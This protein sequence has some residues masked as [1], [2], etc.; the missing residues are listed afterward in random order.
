MAGVVIPTHNRRDGLRSLLGDLAAQTGL[1]AP[2]EVIVVD[3][4]EAEDVSDV[5]ADAAAAG[6]DARLILTANVRATKRN[7]GAEAAGSAIVMFLDDDMRVPPTW[8]AAHLAQQV[9]HPGACVSGAVIFPDAWTQHSNYYR[10][11]Q[12]RHLNRATVSAPAVAIAGNRIV[13]MNLSIPREVWL[14]TGGMDPEFTRYGG[15]DVE[16]GFRLIRDGV[17]LLYAE[18]PWAEHCEVRRD[19]VAYAAQL[20]ESARESAGLLLAKAPEA[21]AVLTFRLTEP[22]CQTGWRDRLAFWGLSAVA[23]PWLVRGL[24]RGLRRVDGRRRLFAPLAYQALALLVARLGSA[25]RLAGRPN[26][27]RAVFA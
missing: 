19:V 13:S 22:G 6:L 8:A 11:K 18:S 14:A 5:V 15:E 23:R 16:L 4:A 27:A 7:A 3:S 9:A 20:Y 12:G 25:D 1:D 24:A 26:R 17:P 2:L 21:R 10:Y